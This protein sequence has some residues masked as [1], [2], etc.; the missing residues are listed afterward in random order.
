VVFCAAALCAAR[1]QSSARQRVPARAI[2]A[3]W[4]CVRRFLRCGCS[5]C[6]LPSGVAVAVGLWE[7]Q[8]AGAERDK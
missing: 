3:G 1:R 5:C 6:C 4:R 8:G 2:A 7:W